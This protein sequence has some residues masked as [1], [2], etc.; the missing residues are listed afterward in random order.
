MKRRGLRQEY[1]ITPEPTAP[2]HDALNEAAL[3]GAVLTAGDQAPG[4]LDQLH[5]ELFY[6]V[7]NRAIYDALSI[8]RRNGDPLGTVA[9]HLHAAKN[10]GIDRFGGLEYVEKMADTA[11]PLAAFGWHLEKAK[12]SA[13]ARA[14]ESDSGGLLSII[15]N[16]STPWPAKAEAIQRF[17]RV[18]APSSP[19][20]KPLPGIVD[21]AEFQV[22][23]LDR[24]PELVKGLLHQGE[25]LAIGGGS[26]SFK[27]FALLDL[28]L[29]IAYG[30]DWLGMPTEPGRVCYCNFEL[31]AW[32]MQRRLQAICKAR[33][34]EPEP[35]RMAVWNLRGHAAAYDKIIPVLIEQLAGGGYSLIVLDPV[36]KLL[37][38]SDEN[39][40]RDI[41][42]LL[43]AVEALNE[44]TS[45]S[46]AFGSH[47][48][49]G[50]QSAKDSIDRISGSGV[51]ARDPDSIL[52]L[53]K[54]KEE[55]TF[56]VEFTL[57]NFPPMQ[58]FGIRWQYPLFV[59]DESLDPED[60]RKANSRPA[61]HTVEKILKVLGKRRLRSVQWQELCEDKG[62]PRSTFY[63]LLRK[64]ENLC[65]ISHNPDDTYSAKAL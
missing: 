41:T 9:L 29:S 10:G 47:F 28:S 12:E 6:D 27:T 57:R 15:K 31:P 56:A 37:G 30:L 32:S 25:K 46:V 1:G 64:S 34:I 62:I 5:G 3:L 14:L 26:K 39:S 18:Y 65:L 60:L 2:P 20:S 45:A 50:N 44:A 58:K 53:T 21:A 38:A 59:R 36:Y 19:E 40:A 61:K 24:P 33:G 8:L 4:L 16:P 35:N 42:A 49:K 11:P 51:F 22:E 7:R 43:N 17:A 63:E 54:L 48:S 52:T 13:A 23:P 55:E